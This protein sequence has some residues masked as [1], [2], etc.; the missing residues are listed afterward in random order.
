MTGSGG[1]NRKD[2]QEDQQDLS[3]TCPHRGECCRRRALPRCSKVPSSSTAPC[4]DL[5]HG[6]ELPAQKVVDDIGVCLK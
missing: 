2:G 4:G 6:V 1:S 3:V 5:R